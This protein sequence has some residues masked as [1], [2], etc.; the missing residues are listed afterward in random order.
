MFCHLR[1]TSV[2][3]SAPELL[4]MCANYKIEHPEERSTIY[5]EQPLEFLA[6]F[7]FKYSRMKEMSAL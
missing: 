4:C 1:L 3:C 5:Y 7:F 6:D 2:T